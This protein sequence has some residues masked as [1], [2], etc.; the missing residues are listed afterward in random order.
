MGGLTL[1]WNPGKVVRAGWVAG[2]MAAVVLC[3]AA[4]G[5]QA[6]ATGTVTGHITCSDTI[7]PGRLASVSL[8]AVPD[9][10][11][12]EVATVRPRGRGGFGPA[13]PQVQA[14]MDGSFVI[15]GVAA[16]NY[17][18]VAQQPGYLSLMSAFG[19]DLQSP[20]AESLERIAKVIPIVSVTPNGSTGVEVRLVRG[21]SISGTV[22]FDDGS[23]IPGLQIA[24]HRRD[25]NGNWGYTSIGGEPTTDDLGRFRIGGLP[26]DE[27]LLGTS[28]VTQNV[29]LFNGGGGGGGFRGGPPSMSS[30]RSALSVFYTDSFL[31]ADAKPIKVSEGQDLQGADIVVANSRLHTLSGSLTDP[32]GHAINTGDV[33]LYTA[34]GNHLMTSAHVDA[35]E[36][37]FHFDF[38]P[39]GQYILRVQGAREVNRD[40]GQRGRGPRGFTS[41]GGGSNVAQTFAPY[42]APLTVQ[43]DTTGM[44]VT[45][46]PVTR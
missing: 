36:R 16:G 37:A 46:Q 15:R 3:G 13:S 24:V 33:D 2:G 44:I 34:V 7:R 23:P 22:R 41:G 18:V 4:R 21:A 10:S 30:L 5:Q 39:E 11:A 31:Q 19:P 29:M 45:L 20:T 17:F 28:I 26:A 12:S 25:K 1:H 8:Q 35:E 38:V 32:A 9:L 40:A 27:Y 42:E 43:S 6:E 14:G